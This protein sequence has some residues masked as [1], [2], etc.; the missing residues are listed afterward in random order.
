MPEINGQDSKE[1]N[2]KQ[3]VSL[4]RADDYRF[5]YTD[6]VQTSVSAFDFKLT[7]S[8]NQTLLNGDVLITEFATI[9][10]S[11]QHAKLLAASLN[12][13]V[14]DYEKNVMPLKMKILQPKIK[15]EK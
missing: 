8:V 11:P 4:A 7:C 14:E 5:F 12:R 1:N 6:N 3:K 15:M 2:E 10:I 13:Q 9:V